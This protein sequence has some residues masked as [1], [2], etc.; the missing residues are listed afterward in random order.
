MN[1][2]TP[3]PRRSD[4]PYRPPTNLAV[5]FAMTAAVPLALFVVAYPAFAVGAAAGALAVAVAR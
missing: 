3:A 4:E 2:Y 1:R 5:A